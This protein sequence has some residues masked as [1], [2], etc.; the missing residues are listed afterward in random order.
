MTTIMDAPIEPLAPEPLGAMLTV[1]EYGD[2]VDRSAKTIKRWIDDGELPDAKRDYRGWWMI[3][4]DAT[5]RIKQRPED[6]L[7][8]SESTELVHS[9]AGGQLISTLTHHLPPELQR[10]HVD[11]LPTFL[12]IPQAAYLLE[13][14]EGTLKN[15]DHRD[16]FQIVT[17]D[18][19]LVVPLYRIKQLRGLTG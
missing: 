17:I 16:Y 12:T 7:F 8:P 2:S 15:P 19:H 1:K 14:S 10:D 3:P 6:Q 4:A 9:P 13:V 18:R 11:K 5:R